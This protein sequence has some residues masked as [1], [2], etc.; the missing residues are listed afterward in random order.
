MA[1]FTSGARST[2]IG[3]VLIVLAVVFLLSGLDI[4]RIGVITKG[5]YFLSAQGDVIVSFIL[6]IVGLAYIFSEAGKPGK[7]KYEVTL[8]EQTMNPK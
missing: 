5:Q 6:T 1:L 2:F 3:V 7:P 8:G 4:F